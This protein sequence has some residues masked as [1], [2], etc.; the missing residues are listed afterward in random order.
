MT[1]CPGSH[2]WRWILI[3][4]PVFLIPEGNLWGQKTRKIEILNA[5]ITAFDKALGDDAR[6]LI[7]NVQLRHEGSLM[8]CDS[9][10]FYPASYS[11]EAYSRVRI[12]QGDT[13]FLYGDRLNYNGNTRFARIRDHVKLIDKETVLTTTYIDYD[14]DKDMAYYLGGG[15]ITNGDNTLTSLK[16]TYYTK[17]KVFYF[18]DSVVIVNPDY[19]IYSDTLRYDTDTEIAYFYGPTEIIGEDNYIYCEGGWYDTRNDVSLVNRRALLKTD[20]RIL[21]GDSLYYERDKGYGRARHH[22]ELTDTVQQ[23]ILRGNFGEYFEESEYAMLTDSALMIQIDKGDSLFVHA[24]TLI[25]SLN[26]DPELTDDS[27]LLRAYYK[28]KIYRKDLQGMCDSLVYIEHDSTFHFIGTPVLW[29]DE[30]QLTASKIEIITRNQELQEMR[31]LGVA[32][33]V[34]QVDTVRFNQIRG[35]T[36]TGHFVKNKLVKIDVNGNGQ[37]IYYTVDQGEV[38]GGMKT[39]CSDMIIYLKDNKLSRVNWLE[40]PSGTFYPLKLFPETETRLPDFKWMDSWRP[41]DS[42]DVYRWE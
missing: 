13:L 24:D 29:S 27:R 28:V 22:V 37:T 3:L 39:E 31:L 35:K 19:H 10:Y 14:R 8:Y 26:P 34:S 11:V 1:L 36:M 16:G 17:D 38:I 33:M 32:M 41:V 20:E 42:L 7:G 2:S 5:D 12:E 23:V 21:K 30:N 4:L 18:K 9:A 25:S 15:E 40:K 6:K